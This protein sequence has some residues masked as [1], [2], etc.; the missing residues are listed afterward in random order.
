MRDVPI[1]PKCKGIVTYA[2]KIAEKQGGDLWLFP[3]LTNSKQG[4]AHNWQN[5]AN[6]KF[7]RVTVG[8]KDRQPGRRRY[9]HSMHSFRHWFSTLCREIMPGSREIRAHGHSLGKGEGGKMAPPRRSSCGRTG[10]PRLI[11]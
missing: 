3:S 2:A 7:L 1:H 6:R 11:H 8:I 5:Y 4:R 9:D 10:S